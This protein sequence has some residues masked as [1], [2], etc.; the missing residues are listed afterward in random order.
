MAAPQNYSGALAVRFSLG[1][2]EGAVIP[3]FA[4]FTSQWHTKKEQGTRVGIWFSLNGFAQIFGGQIVYAIAKGVRL[5]TDIPDGEITNFFSQLI[6]SFGYTPE[7]NLL[8]GTPGGAVEIVTLIACGILGDRYGNR[9]LNSPSGL[10]I[11]IPGMVLIVAL[12]LSNA[13]GRLV[14]DYLTQASL[15]PFITLLALIATHVAGWTKKT[16]V[17]AL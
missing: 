7:Q 15:T 2:F 1:V 6:V 17:A 13:G 5:H 14:W 4:L 10:I 3:Y 16:T 8:Y 11:A 9:L 12:P